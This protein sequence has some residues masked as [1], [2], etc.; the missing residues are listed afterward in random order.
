MTAVTAH[1]TGPQVD[2][3]A[4]G[5]PGRTPPDPSPPAGGPWR[6]AL[7]L[8]ALELRLVFRRRV[9]V[10]SAVLLPLAL[11]G[12]TFIGGRPTTREAWGAALGIHAI[13]VLLMTV[14]LTTALVL[15]TRRQT[16]VFKRLRTT[17]L[18][19]PGLLGA[20]VGP[21]AALG[22][23]QFAFLTVV[24]LATGAPAPAEP[25]VAA[26]GAGL[27]LV[28]AV[29]AAAATAAL[30][31]SVERVQITTMPLFLGAAVGSQIVVGDFAVELSWAA[32]AVP[33]VA[34]SDLVFR[35]WTG[36]GAGVPDLGGLS[37][38]PAGLGLLVSWTV[39]AVVIFARTWRWDPRA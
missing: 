17:E 34:V 20:V 21:V 23:A 6:R 33:L 9:T 5:R 37:A 12:L 16:L 24:N 3:R 13:L 39:V 19:G 2:P 26:A 32:L 27:G 10:G 25:L 4:A 18:T 15:T 11:F 31:S 14:Y 36:G 22:L 1:P 8:A 35:G 7:S 28:L 38:L 29:A 30:T